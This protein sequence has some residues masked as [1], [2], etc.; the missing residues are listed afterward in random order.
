M[1]NDPFYNI[2]KQGKWANRDV[3]FAKTFVKPLAYYNKKDD[4]SEARSVARTR[5]LRG[6]TS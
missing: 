3:R 6:E 1:V 4:H 2:S 5:A